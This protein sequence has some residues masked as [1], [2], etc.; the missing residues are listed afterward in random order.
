METPPLP[1]RIET[2]RLVLRGYRVGDI[3]H[4]VPLLNDWS[5]ARWL[6]NVPHPYTAAQ[7][8]EWVEASETFR[9][10]GRALCL[11]IARLDDDRP[12][13]GI[14]LN[15]ER[16]EVGY[17]V[18]VPHQGLGYASEALAAV[19][20][21]AFA[22]LELPGL[23]AATLLDNRPS[24]RVLEKAGFEHR[25]VHDYDFALRGGVQPGH[26][27]TLG[28]ARWRARNGEMAS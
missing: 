18:G 16:G 10:E 17:W 1:A 6:A 23:T 28:A 21:L 19:L 26:I 22:E 9:L 2:P 3:K 5:V 4:L 24:R 14:E 7:A 25:G 15:V 12:V 27:Y 11:L 8:R 20:R 13:G